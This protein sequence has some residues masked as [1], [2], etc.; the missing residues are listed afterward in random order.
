MEGYQCLSP[1]NQGRSLLWWMSLL[2]GDAGA[3]D[4]YYAQELTAG[5]GR[6]RISPGG[7]Y[8][9]AHT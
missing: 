4:G 5:S 8:R 2:V 6:V 7:A 3:Q 9:D 1:M